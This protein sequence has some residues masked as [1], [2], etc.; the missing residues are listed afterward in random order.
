MIVL[1]F[2]VTIITTTTT[3]TL[4]ITIRSRIE[5]ATPPGSLAEVDGAVE[6]VAIVPA[7]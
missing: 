6:V 5:A 2:A 4:R 1:V 3:I 7:R